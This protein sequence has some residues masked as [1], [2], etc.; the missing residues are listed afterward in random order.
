MDAAQFFANALEPYAA[1]FPIAADMLSAK[2]NSP[3][4]QN[5]IFNYLDSLSVETLVENG[6]EE[7]TTLAKMY[8]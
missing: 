6:L 2:Y 3:V 8:A 4:R 7:W 1:T 5:Q